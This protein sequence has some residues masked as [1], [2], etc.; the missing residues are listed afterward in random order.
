MHVQSNL[1]ASLIP[2][3]PDIVSIQLTTVR[4]YMKKKVDIFG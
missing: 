4:K 2:T 3:A 1:I